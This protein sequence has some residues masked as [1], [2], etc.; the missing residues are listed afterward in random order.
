LR[1]GAA[2]RVDGL[3]LEALG[4]DTARAARSRRTSSFERGSRRHRVR[5]RRRS[6]PVHAHGIAP[7]WYAA[8]NALFGRFGRFAPT[9]GSSPD[10]I[11]DPEVGRV[12]VNEQEARER[13]LAFEATVYPMAQLD[14]A[15]ADGDLLVL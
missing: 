2:P 13:K 1:S 4:I 7:A 11:R 14:R 9:T 3:G 6:L 8:V 12:G 10:D 15:I 5:R